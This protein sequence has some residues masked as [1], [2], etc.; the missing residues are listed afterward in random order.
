MDGEV[1]SETLFSIRFPAK[2]TNSG[3]LDIFDD[4]RTFAV[5]GE[6][7]DLIIIAQFKG[8]DS[9][10]GSLSRWKHRVE[11]MSTSVAVSAAGREVTGG[12]SPD[13]GETSNGLPHDTVC[14]PFASYKKH[15]KKKVG[16]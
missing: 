2:H 11:S 9:N 6:A 7:I 4:K 15:G 13:Y 10:D 14:T 5:I 16:K 8:D 12:P 3:K 1:D